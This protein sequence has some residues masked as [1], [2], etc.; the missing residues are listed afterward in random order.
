MTVGDLV[1]APGL[2]RNRG[3]DSRGRTLFCGCPKCSN[4]DNNFPEE[5]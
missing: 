4:K 2:A 3:P 5:N 1:E